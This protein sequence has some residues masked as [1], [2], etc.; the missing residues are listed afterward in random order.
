MNRVLKLSLIFIA[1]VILVLLWLIGLWW[2]TVALLLLGALTYL[3]RFRIGH[4][5]SRTLFILAILLFTAFALRIFIFEIFIVPSRSMESLL[6]PGDIL[7]MSKTTFGP[8]IR[9]PWDVSLRRESRSSNRLRLS[10]WR[11]VKRND[12]IIFRRDSI[13]YVKRCVGLP[14]EEVR[15]NSGDIYLS[16]QLY[17]APA[18]IKRY[19]RIWF[20]DRRAILSMLDHKSIAAEIDQQRPFA[21]ALIT[22][23]FKSQL[24]TMP[25]VDSVVLLCDYPKRL[26]AYPLSKD[27]DWTFDNMGPILIPKAGMR[28]ELN[29][30]TYLL[31]GNL[32]GKYEGAKIDFANGAFNVGDSAISEY[33]FA[34]DYY[35]LMGDNRFVS[36]DSRAWG[37]IPFYSIDGVVDFTL[38]HAKR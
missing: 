10:G 24:E 35:F 36:D 32:I 5:F 17:E 20:N 2:L 9:V 31:Y 16:R 37:F 22:T 6:V 19:F 21:N 15:I 4:T 29:P 18:S 34:N 38:F 23:E 7:L 13:S 14:G 1:F 28:I 25:T 12:V 26:K 11:N 30:E 3:V 33:V 27:L 8:L